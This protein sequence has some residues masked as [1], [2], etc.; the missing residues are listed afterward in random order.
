[1]RRSGV[2]LLVAALAVGALVAAG[3]VVTGLWSST[4][5]RERCQAHAGRY[6]AS[7]GLEEAENAALIAAISVR[8]GMPPRA[9]TIALATAYQESGLRNLDYG[10]LDSL[11]LFQQRPSQGWGSQE[12]ILDP[13]YAANRFYR[14]LAKVPGYTGLEI[15]DAAQRV[16]RSA[17]G[18]AYS[19]HESNARALASALTGQSAAA[20]SCTMRAPEEGAAASGPVVRERLDRAF[21]DLVRVDADRAGTPAPAAQP[22]ASVTREA[23]RIGVGSRELGWAVAQWAVA[24]A[25]GLGI[26]SVSY[27]GR[28]WDRE[29]SRDGWRTTDDSAGAA[30]SGTSAVRVRLDTR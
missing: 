8:R 18:G 12:Q 13:Y 29:R 30:P 21:G 1:M 20:F 19:Q 23:L 28:T 10:H 2:R 26:T 6:E 4:P 24:N 22:A 27:D 9:A 16:Q 15:A 25:S 3:V 7:L 14:A 11:G 17:D 5:I